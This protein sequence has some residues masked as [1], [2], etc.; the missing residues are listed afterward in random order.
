MDGKKAPNVSGVDSPGRRTVYS[1]CGM[2]AVRCPIQV[3]VEDGRVVWV[4]GNPN[5]KGMGTSLCAKGAA[6]IPFEYDDERPQYPLIRTGPRGSGQWRRATWDEALDYIADK[7]KEVIEKY[8]GKGVALSDRGGPFNDLTKTFIKS[9]GSPNYFN[10][11]C[12]CGRNAHHAAKSLFGMGRKDWG[13]DI[14]NTKHLVLYGRNM[15]ESLQVKEAKDFIE[16]LGKGAKVTYIDVRATLTASKASRFWM[17]RPNTEYALNL[18]WINV[19]LAEKLYNAEFV[20]KWVEGLDELESF[21]KEYTPEWAEKVTGVS[22]EEI[23]AAIREIAADAP[24]VIFHLGWMTA[25]HRQSFHTSRTAHILNALMGN[26]E[27]TGGLIA[28]KGPGD[29]GLKGVNKLEDRVTKPTDERVDQIGTKYKHWDSGPGLAHM[30]F[31]NMLTGEP[32]QV[33]AYFAY[34]H[35]PLTSIPD[36]EA[37]QKGMDKL[38]LLV[39]IDVNYSETAW[40][41]DVI[42]PETTYLERGSLVAQKKGGK[43]SLQ[44]RDQCIAPRFDSRPAWWIFREILRRMGKS[45]ALEFETIEDIWHYQLDGT[46]VSPAQLR[47]K[48]VIGLAKD[49]IMRDRED[50]L[51][52]KTASGKIEIISPVLSEAGLPSLAPFYEAPPKEPGQFNLVFGR[53]GWLA[54]GQ[55]TNN[56][57]LNELMPENALWINS[58]VAAELGIA[59]GDTIKVSSDGAEAVGKVKVTEYIHP[60]AAFMVHGF[61]RT[62]PLQTRAYKK[63]M[64]DQRLM[65]G[66]LTDYDPAGGGNNLTETVVTVTKA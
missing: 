47:E 63:G 5:D 61:G 41:A 15:I 52:F 12:T 46:G 32:Y 28:A 27:V 36:P 57:L 3:E 54:H 44:V 58:K 16:A 30:L 13:M 18:A 8:G 42:L 48:G 50:G 49:A 38:D 60:E 51:G 1:I 56:P 21:V 19:V 66:K 64:A 10:H 23:K 40:Y 24:Q 35:D 6:G 34:R 29:Y 31:A 11:D 55:S 39:A 9:L 26:F 37:I 59:D 20:S 45:E 33:G 14:K 43:P 4:Q 17:I 62:V 22:A 53:V 2:C 65:K 25:R 7:L